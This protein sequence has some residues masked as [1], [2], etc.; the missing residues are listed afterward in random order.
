MQTLK[1]KP[2]TR[3]LPHQLYKIAHCTILSSFE[4]RK[5][6]HAA[7][8]FYSDSIKNQIFMLRKGI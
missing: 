3:H 8:D 7:P 6:G 5:L 4:E 1:D 2:K